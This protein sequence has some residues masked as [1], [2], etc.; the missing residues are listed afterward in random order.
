MQ[1]SQPSRSSSGDSS[2]SAGGSIRDH[3]VSVNFY[4][5]ENGHWGT[6][7]R[8][9]GSKNGTLLHVRSDDEKDQDKFR[10][11]DRQQ[12]FESP[13]L[14]GSTTVGKLS[15]RETAA[16]RASIRSY[17]ADDKNIPRYSRGTN[18][19]NFVGGSLAQL[20]QD[21]LLKAGHSQYLTQHY[22]RRGE[23]IGNDLRRDGR[24]FYQ[25]EEK[26]KGHPA[27]RYGEPSVRRAPKKLDMAAYSHLSH[28]PR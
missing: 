7:M 3:E 18:C 10:Y 27:A 22:G 9:R 21:G 11:E 26:K 23:D 16:A 12:S 24:H 20:E 25:V 8:R 28:E 17:G 6:F 14:Y 13:S 4:S 19:Q 5:P 1:R 2:K 15:A